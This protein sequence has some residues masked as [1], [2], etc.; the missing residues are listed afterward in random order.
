[1]ELLAKL[2]EEVLSDYKTE[3]KRGTDDRGKSKKGKSFGGCIRY[4]MGKDNAEI[5]A[6]GRCTARKLTEK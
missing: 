4:V 5:I 3:E 6:S 2:K 1:M